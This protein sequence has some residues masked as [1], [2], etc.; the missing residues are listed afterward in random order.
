MKTYRGVILLIVALLIVVL[1]IGGLFL[2]Y[3]LNSGALNPLSVFQGTA[4]DRYSDPNAYPWEEGHLFIN[5]KGDAY[6]MGGRRP[7][8]GSQPSIDNKLCYNAE[9]YDHGQ[10]R[11]QITLTIHNDGDA[12]ANWT[13]DFTIGGRRYKA[14]KSRDSKSGKKMNIFSGNIAALKIY[15]DENGKDKSKLYVITGGFFHLQGPREEESLSGAG[16]ITAWIDKDYTAE[17]KLAIL[18]FA[19]GEMAIFDWGPVVVSEQ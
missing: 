18:S 6:H 1:S 3:V 10:Q 5:K 8:F 7:P 4:V 9:V 2:L 13:G 15:E 11:G 16:Y 17:G 12:R 14:V 19:A